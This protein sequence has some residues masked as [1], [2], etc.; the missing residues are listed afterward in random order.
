MRNEGPEGWVVGWLLLLGGAAGLR[1]VG[2]GGP[3]IPLQPVD[4]ILGP[5]VVGFTTC[6]EIERRRRVRDEEEGFAREVAAWRARHGSRLVTAGP[7][8][9]APASG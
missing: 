3:L 2:V 6:L 5:A 7:S 1:L 4:A 8:S 9:S